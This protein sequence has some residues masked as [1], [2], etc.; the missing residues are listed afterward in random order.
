MS[1][2]NPILVTGAAGRVDAVGRTVVGLLRQRNLRVRAVVRR[3]NECA[4]ALSAMGAEVVVGDPTRG[5]DVAHAFTPKP[6]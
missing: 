1:S 3:H 5:T 6:L 2:Y 4:E